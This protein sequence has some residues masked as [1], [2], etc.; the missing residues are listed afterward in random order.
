MTDN[1]KQ[2]EQIIKK[3]KVDISSET[4]MDALREYKR[5]IKFYVK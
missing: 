3:Q 5:N 2:L 4:I 1:K